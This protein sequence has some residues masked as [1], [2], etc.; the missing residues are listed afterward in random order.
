MAGTSKEGGKEVTVVSLE[1]GTLTTLNGT[2]ITAV[3]LGGQ[4]ISNATPPYGVST[5][6]PP[7]NWASPP[8]TP[9]IMIPQ[10][11]QQQPL[12]LVV[13]DSKKE[14]APEKEKPHS[15]VFTRL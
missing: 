7:G 14:A 2:T 12:I 6:P 10:Q 13:A 8:V 5:W 9:V 4:P 11:Q 15:R 3:P 1:P